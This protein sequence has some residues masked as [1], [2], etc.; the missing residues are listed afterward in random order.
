[1]PLQL[2]L[3]VNND[4]RNVATIRAF[5]SQALR[6][7]PLVESNIDSLLELVSRSAEA[8]IE[9]GYPTGEEGNVKVVISEAGDKLVLTVRDYGMPQDVRLLEQ[10]LHERDPSTLCLFGIPCASFT[11]EIHWIGYGPKGKALKITKWLHDMHVT[12]QVATETLKTFED[13]VPL[14]PEQQYVIRRMATYEAV[15]VSQLIYRAY[16]STYFNH[17]VYYPK[18]VAALNEQGTVLSFVAQG[19]NGQLVGHYALERNQDGPVGEGGQAVVDPAHRGRGLLTR[20]KEA[21]TDEARRLGLLGLYADAV[22]VHTMTQKSNVDHRAQVT[23]V[24]LGIAPKS[25]HFRGISEKQTQR[26]TCLMYFQWLS[27]PPSRSVY[28]PPAHREVLEAIYQRLQCAV[29]FK[30]G[31]APRGQ[32][33]RTVRMDPHARKAFIRTDRL[34]ED[35]VIGICN[36]KQELTEHSHVEAVFVEL[37]LEDP[38]TPSVALALEDH[39]FAFAGIAPHFSMRGDVLRLIYLTEPLARA[40]IKTY[41]DCSA[42]LLDYVLAEQTRVRGLRMGRHFQNK[43]T[44]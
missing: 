27:T 3:T 23:C 43:G 16:G 44:S 42:H 28:A 30:E 22:T 1:M 39:G 2:E 10:Q 6:Q 21:A 36:T 35:S 32:G 24:D 41:E 40:P 26:V 34:G 31:T 8:A 18:R 19:E 12:A 38:G 14:A 5:A 4:R 13:D 33:T 9:H 25:E 20:M 7:I 15:Q 17:D 29:T 37:P 11:D